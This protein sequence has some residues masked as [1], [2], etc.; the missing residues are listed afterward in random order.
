MDLA[1]RTNRQRVG[2]LR[3]LSWKNLLAVGSSGF[4]PTSHDLA[5]AG[6]AVRRGVTANRLCARMEAATSCLSRDGLVLVHRD[7]RAS[8]RIGASRR[9]I[10]GGPLHIC[11]A[12]RT[13]HSI[14]LGSGGALWKKPT[15]RKRISTAGRDGRLGFAG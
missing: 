15:I 7:A 14:G 2:G 13:V 6:G 4:L 9:A 5:F 11:S 8:Y 3:S 1:N 10:A 12:D